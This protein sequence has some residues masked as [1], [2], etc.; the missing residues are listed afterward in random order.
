[1]KR[2]VLA[3]A[4]ICIILSSCGSGAP[5]SSTASSAAKTFSVTV[6]GTKASLTD[7]EANKG[8]SITLT[9]T[10]DATEEVHLHG[11]DIHFD[12]TAGVPLTKS[13]VAA[14]TGQFEFELE[15][16]SMHLGN[17]VVNP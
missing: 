17:L 9:F 7:L 8:D 3:T 15:A 5:T 2:R 14:N 10:T 1:M 11:Y 6:T 4:M 12:C 13:F 16:T